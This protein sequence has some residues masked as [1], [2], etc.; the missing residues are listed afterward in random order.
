VPAARIVNPDIIEA[1]HNTS[2]GFGMA[3]I[4]EADGEATVNVQQ[5]G[6]KTNLFGFAYGDGKQWHGLGAVQL[7]ADQWQHVAAVCDGENAMICG[8]NAAQGRYIV[9]GDS[10]G[11]CTT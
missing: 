7:I 5:E 1:N 9:M 6:M 4:L 3:T 8:I 2:C 11:S 10:D